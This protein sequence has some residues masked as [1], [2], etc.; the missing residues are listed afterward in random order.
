M[1][2]LL[3]DLGVLVLLTAAGIVLEEHTCG[4]PA[5]RTGWL[6]PYAAC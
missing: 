6:Q 1:T 2:R 3:G 5:P 4:N